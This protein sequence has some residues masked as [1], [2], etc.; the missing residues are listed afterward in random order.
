MVV[1]NI[2]TTSE[3]FLSHTH[4]ENRNVRTENRKS[5]KGGNIESNTPVPPKSLEP[6]REHPFLILCAILQQ[7]LINVIILSP[8]CARKQHWVGL[9]HMGQSQQMSQ[10]G[11]RIAPCKR[12][13]RLDVCGST[14]ILRNTLKC[15]R[16][17][18]VSCS[19][20][21]ESAGLVF[22]EEKKHTHTQ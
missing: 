5:K 4:T 6:D 22:H 13:R 18:L 1:V 10:N 17:E 16:I 14:K 21:Y 15:I 2:L 8:C 20:L 7:H 19:T 11:A 3:H 9:L 12:E